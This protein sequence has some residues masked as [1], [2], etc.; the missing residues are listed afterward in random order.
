MAKIL[1]LS[2]QYS[3]VCRPHKNIAL[4]LRGG[5]PGKKLGAIT[6]IGTATQVRLHG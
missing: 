5:A 6:A 1:E 4:N 2:V 3:I